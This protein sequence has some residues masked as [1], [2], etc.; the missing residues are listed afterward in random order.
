MED[1]RSRGVPLL[2]GPRERPE[3][4]EGSSPHPPGNAATPAPPASRRAPRWIGGLRIVSLLTLLSRVLGLIRDVLMAAVFGSGPMMDA[5]SVA[6]RIPNLARRLFGEGALSTAFLPVFMRDADE[7]GPESAWRLA[8]T[9]FAGLG[10][11][12]LVVVLLGEGVL[13]AAGAWGQTSPDVRL[14]LF[15]TAVLLPYLLLICLAAQL[16]A[17]HHAREQFARPALLPVLLNLVWIATLL[18]VVPLFES[19]REKI[20]AV[21]VG[22]LAGGTL[23]LAAPLLALFRQ[24]FRLRTDWRAHRRTVSRLWRALLPVLLGLSITQINTLADSVIA[25]AFSPSEGGPATMPLWGDL[26]YPMPAGT[27]SAL[28]FAQRMYQFPL[29]VFGVALGTVLFPLF[30]RQAHAG[31]RDDLRRSIGLGMRLVVAIG[32]PASAGLMLLAAPVTRLLFQ[33]GE[34]D[35]VSAAR[36]AELIAVYGSAVWAFCGLLILQR[37]FFAVGDARTPLKTGLAAVAVNLTLDFTLIWFWGGNGLAAATAVAAVL[38][39]GLTA[40][41]LQSRIGRLDW[42]AFATTTCKT[43]LATGVMS[44]ACVAL[45]AVWSESPGFAPRLLRAGVPLLVSIAVYAAA[46]KLLR[47]E[48]PWLLLRRPGEAAPRIDSDSAESKG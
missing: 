33:H 34:F 27:A 15:L 40:I 44:A 13:W 20:T 37:A 36:T 31:A 42:P 48:E 1:G 38:Q 26:A 4:I 21:A 22:I 17:V 2:D 25:W 24:G 39:V 35:A 47:L 23:Q 32:L 45:L 41:L 18:G 5:F 6:F 9:V 46:A 12:L 16:S 10:A 8:A 19:P 11:L 28:Y 43:I 30:A 14:L 7:R 3:A 29:G